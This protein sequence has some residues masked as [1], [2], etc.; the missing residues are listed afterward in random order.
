MNIELVYV[1]V[2]YR[3]GCITARPVR[4]PRENRNIYSPFA[5]KMCRERE[6]AYRELAAAREREAQLMPIKYL[7]DGKPMSI[8][9]R[10]D[11]Y[12]RGKRFENGKYIYKYFGK[13]DPRLLLEEVMVNE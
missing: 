5:C 13:A 6:Q 2:T 12:W 7:V 10:K 9:Q 1:T 4:P 11:G 8:E 3:C